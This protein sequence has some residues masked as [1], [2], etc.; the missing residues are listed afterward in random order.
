MKIYSLKQK[1]K[2]KWLR[3]VLT[4][5]FCV[6]SFGAFQ[7]TAE[8]QHERSEIPTTE[9]EQITLE[10]AIQTALNEN[11]ELKAIRER[12][13]VEQARLDGIA[14]IGNPAL[15]TEVL[16]GDT[17]ETN[18]GLTKSFQLGGQRGHRKRLAQSNISKVN[19]EIAD[20]E[21]KLHLAVKLAFY[22]LLL[23]QE[24]QRL[25]KEIVQLSEQVLE[26]ATIQFEAGEISV[27]EVNLAKITRQGALRAQMA[28]ENQRESA[29]VELN[30]L[31]GTP[32]ERQLIASGELKSK[33]VRLNL[34]ALK[35]YALANRADLKAFQLEAQANQNELALAKAKNVP[36]LGV[37]LITRRTSEETLFG[38]RFSIPLP[39]F[40]RNRDG[41]GAAK[42]Q[43]HVLQAEISNQERQISREVVG[44]YMKV[45]ATQKML[46]FY[47]GGIL[48]LLDENLELVRTAYELGEAELLE[49]ILTQNE[50]ISTK[51]AHL[52]A[53]AT[54]TQ[55]LAELSAAV[56]REAT[57]G[58]F[59]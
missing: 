46:S 23:I 43:Q 52:D 12:I 58:G 47:E 19:A 44:A 40:D 9:G 20:A 49:V 21:R 29:Q 50:F 53:L 26:I 55:T 24:K 1:T 4:I 17:G 34:D 5:G 27:T 2:I 16:P 6:L 35:A 57:E 13:N 10:Q 31:M 51:N 32:I 38:G 59:E 54:Y 48:D 41:I 36:E 30:S 18:V 8:A 7:R 39:F 25:A 15:E 14:L 56:G 37:S 33:P 45:L 11:L 3:N 28:L 42:A 22:E